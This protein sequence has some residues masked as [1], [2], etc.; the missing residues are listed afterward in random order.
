MK[1]GFIGLGIMGAPMAGHLRAAG[2][3]LFVHTRSRMPEALT[4]AGAQVCAS[5]REV[6]QR[7]DIVFTML[8]DTPD[9]A[10]VLFGPDGVAEGLNPGKTV[11]DMSSISPLETKAFAQRINALGCKP[12]FDDVD[13]KAAQAI[14]HIL[15]RAKAY[16]VVAGI[17]N[18][19]PDVA[20]AR[21]A[22]GFRFVT[23]SSDAR[24]LAAGSQDLLAAM[25]AG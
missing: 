7:A 5:A 15:E 18:G 16:G 13:P 17:H 10:Q 12:V 6:A 22:K 14:A 23:V 9:V 25:R 11:V 2:H 4:Q 24:I 21:I 1:I 8:P 20:R 19:R 3:E